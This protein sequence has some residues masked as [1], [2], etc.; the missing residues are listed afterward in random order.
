MSQPLH[1]VP[2]AAAIKRQGKLKFWLIIS[3]VLAVVVI[4]VVGAKMKDGGEKPTSVSIEKAM[5]KTITQVVTATGK[6]Q[7]E[8]EVRISSEV[9][10]ELIDIPVKEGQN[11]KKGDV[12]AR[13]KDDYYQ[14]QVDQQEAALASARAD[15]VSSRANLEKAK[16]DFA[17]SD[18]LF[19][20]KLV[21][22]QEHLSAKTTLDV[23]QAT[24][25]SSLAQIRRCEGLLNQ[26][27]DQIN[28]TTVF[29]PMDGTVSSLSCKVGERVLGTGQFAG[30][31]IMRVADLNSMEVRV[32]VNE[33]DIVNVKLGDRSIVAID[34]FPNRKFEGKVY[35]ISNSALSSASSAS[36]NAAAQAASASDEVTNFL[37]KIRVTDQ[38]SV[39]LRPGMSASVD[40]ETKTVTDAVVV[41]IQSVTV[42]AEGGKT[43]DELREEKAKQAQ[44]RSGNDLEV[45]KEKD[46]ARRSRDL[47]KR[48][49]FVVNDGK[50]SLRPVET[51]IADNTHIEI[52]SGVKKD[53]VVVSGSYAAISRLL[54]DGMKVTIEKVK[55]EDKK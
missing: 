8:I 11:V 19:A 17:Q 28:K 45:S 38:G 36:T 12:L 31:E 10:G 39:N 18:M 24:Y 20:R 46:N 9:A 48:V 55:K 27:R 26:V 53:E 34:A 14:A 21:S 42:R 43:S 30:T 13:I 5:I 1:A 50:V 51:G 23:A 47:L 22:D 3:G 16:S 52:L 33:N 49:I 29:S 37:V 15:C 7:P 40:I 32:K 35:E 6:I 4:A 44:E 54:K 2:N 41:P 25:E